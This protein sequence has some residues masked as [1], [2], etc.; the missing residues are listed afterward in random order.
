[1]TRLG[2]DSDR[3]LKARK[4]EWRGT[5]GGRPRVRAGERKKKM[6]R[7][8][9]QNDCLSLIATISRCSDAGKGSL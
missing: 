2:H 6:R 5:V 3:I 1:M 4:D 8:Y 7:I 9:R